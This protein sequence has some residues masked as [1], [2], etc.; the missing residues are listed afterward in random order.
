MDTYLCACIHSHIFT[1]QRGDGFPLA[2]MLAQVSTD[3]KE[4]GPNLAAHIYT[5]CPTA[6]PSLPDP[7]PDAS[8]DDLMRSLGMLQHADGNFENFERFLG[9]TEV[10]AA[11]STIISSIF[12]EEVIE[13][14]YAHA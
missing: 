7:A 5:V 12:V 9:R 13:M 4:L 10:G 1:S 2:N 14:L 3:H 11:A 8:E 6:I